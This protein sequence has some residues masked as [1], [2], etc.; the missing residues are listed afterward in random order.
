MDLHLKHPFYGVLHAQ[1]ELPSEFYKIQELLNIEEYLDSDKWNTRRRTVTLKRTV[2]NYRLILKPAIRHARRVELIDPFMSCRD[3]KFM[4]IVDTVLELAADRH[5]PANSLTLHIH[6]G[7]PE[8]N[9]GSKEPV[10]KRLNAWKNALEPRISEKNLSVTVLL[11]DVL[12]DSEKFHDRFIATD[13]CGISIPGGLDCL[14]NSSTTFALLDEEDRR[15]WLEAYNPA[16]PSTPY[17]LMGKV[18]LGI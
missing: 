12:V 4:K 7:N 11:W 1:Q 14:P 6:A 8:R 17:D 2:D 13:Q 10:D 5:N 9:K 3:P 16:N 15:R 18:K